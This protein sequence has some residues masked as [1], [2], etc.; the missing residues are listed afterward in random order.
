MTT[1]LLN[2]VRIRRYLTE[3]LFLIAFA[4]TLGGLIAFMQ[5]QAYLQI[6]SRE[7][8][9][10]TSQVNVVEKNLTPLLFS[11]RRALD[12]LVENLTAGKRQ[13]VGLELAKERLEFLAATLTAFHSILIINDEGVVIASSVVG[14]I[15]Q[16]VAQRDY[17]QAALKHPDSSQL[18]VTPPIAGVLVPSVMGL[19]R[20]IPGNRGRFGG[21]AMISFAPD[22][23][24]TLL[25]SVRYTPDTTTSLVHGD[26]KLFQMVPEKADLTGK[27]LSVPDSF[28]TRH[29][30]S[31]RP[32]SV[33]D[34]VTYVTGEK[35]KIAFRTVRPA[36]LDMDKALVVTASR[37]YQAI[38]EAWRRETAIVGGLF[39]VLAAGA[40][41]SLLL[42]Q[43]RQRHFERIAGRQQRDLRASEA[44]LRG[45]F[46]NTNTGIAS[47]D[48]QGR[49]VHFN[50][51]FRALLGYDAEP[52]KR[53]NFADF[54]HP[55]DLRLETSF[56]N[57]ILAGKR[58]HY[59][60]TK[61]YIAADDT[62]LWVDID[63][64]AIR[65]QSGEVTKF[66]G[67][68]NDITE[69][70]EAETQLKESELRLQ[71]IIDNEPECIKI[72]DAQGRLKQINPAGL[73]MIEADSLEQAATRPMIDLVAPQYRAAYV[74]LHRRVLA[75]EPMQMEFEVIGFK[76]R[77]RWLETHAVPMRDNGETVHLAITR[78]ITESKQ[79]A[80][81]LRIAAAA[82]E[83]Q[84]GIVVTDANNM[85]LRVN[86]AFT[87]I[88]GYTADEVVGKNPSLLKSGHHNQD[89][90]REM[91]E[92]I[93]S[94]GV[95]QGEIWDRRKNGEEYPK[96]L[97]ISAVKDE[98]GVVTHYVGTH[99]DISK[100]KQADE[101]IVQ[102]AYF[103]QLTGLPNRTLFQDRLKQAMT[104]SGRS[105]SHCALLIIDLDNF[106]TLND[107]LGHDVGDQLLK[108][109]SQRLSQCVREGDTVARLGGDEFVVVLAGLSATE[110][111]AAADTEGV[112]EKILA[113][114]N[115]I[116]RFGHVV[117]QSTAS[118]GVTL[119]K[120]SSL[121]ID[122]LLKQADLTMY[123]AKEGGR[124]TVRFFDPTMETAIQERMAL[125]NDLRRALDTQ[126]FLLHY[127]AQVADGGRIKGAEV[128]VRWRHPRLGMMSPGDFIP[129]AEDTGLIVPLGQWVLETACGQLALWANH[130]ETAQLT[131]AVNVSARQFS[132]PDF[133]EQVLATLER[134]G[135]NPERLR[136]E[137]TESLLADNLQ[138][139]AGKMFALKDR[140][141]RFSLDDFGT[142]YS[143]LSYLKRLPL[144]QLKI[145][146][147]FVRDVLVD[148]NDAA[149]ARTI[150]ALAQ[151]LGLGVIAEGVETEEQRNFLARS[152]CHAYQG[153]L[154]SK[155]LPLDGFMELMEIEAFQ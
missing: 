34:G 90:Y 151:S 117:H 135:A 27:D 60:I 21:I 97:T 118:I 105:S 121:S 50:E 45:I 77:R 119:F 127:Q 125:E 38:F 52:L 19:Y 82:F 111:E 130:P 102:L 142:G 153:Y 70:R 84:E 13:D 101:K 116:Y 67:V 44:W 131:L 15:G 33:F 43:R 18:H 37:D 85:I 26:G 35:R 149:I 23:F 138:D 128:L 40:V 129:L 17:F 110:S 59:R 68:V 54:T 14:L 136:L 57:E 137:L 94:T 139:I 112:A 108:Q 107:T 63:V 47:T 146:Q 99:F 7:D 150:V 16:N 87:K 134:T 154:F 12:Q 93:N 69:R 66:V 133:V 109:V 113:T 126:Q 144:Y 49:V 120:G 73:A 51:A 114:L 42:Y 1:L 140:G 148:A 141:V 89:F 79:A 4:S 9:R 28:F 5:Y 122:D 3:W 96:W 24:K 8:E 55:E 71:A 86:H 2:L 30:D 56:F 106:K 32:L 20:I 78:D 80:A 83:S 65:D 132:Q 64:S 46:E 143:S 91:W 104:I 145:D 123:K 10:L 74:D 98:G 147:S 88:T 76:G 11:A 92:S 29:R 41:L 61:R 62:V 6:E 155:P 152:G 103:D 53:M 72:L 39:M 124:N 25:D 48:N 22:S 31:G 100:S 58:N 115:R 75:G 81:D 36:G 95:W